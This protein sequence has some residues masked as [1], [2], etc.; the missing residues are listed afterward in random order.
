MDT[1]VVPVD[2]PGAPAAPLSPSAL[3]G[4]A[5]RPVTLLPTDPADPLYEPY[6]NENHRDHQAAVHARFQEASGGPE[7]WREDGLERPGPAEPRAP[8]MLATP[9]PH[10]PLP[11]DTLRA[12]S[13]VFHQITPSK[14]IG[15]AALDFL[16]GGPSD[17]LPELPPDYQPAD[18]SATLTELR[19]GWGAKAEE[20]LRLA[21]AVVDVYDRQRGGAVREYLNRT[22]LG[23]DPRVIR[24]AT[25]TA[26]QWI[27]QGWRP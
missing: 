6:R 26:R 18:P 27:K 17:R 3:P 25:R 2:T 15:Q 20:N 12:V 13:N 14:E 5:A 24:L 16:E 21:Q 11:D 23:N 8:W 4:G 19:R 1:P 22:G 9:D 7:P 10:T